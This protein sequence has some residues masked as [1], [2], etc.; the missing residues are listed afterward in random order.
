M[1]GAYDAAHGGRRHE[2][3]CCQPWSEIRVPFLF[4]AIVYLKTDHAIGCGVCPECAFSDYE[5]RVVAAVKRD[6]GSL[7]DV[8]HVAAPGHG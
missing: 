3:F 6:L 7:D 4:L 1:I 8:R 2:C 5:A